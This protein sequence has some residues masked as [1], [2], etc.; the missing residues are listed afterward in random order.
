M[1]SRSDW[2]NPS[3]GILKN[4]CLSV[5]QPNYGTLMTEA[6]TE[7]IFEPNYLLEKRSFIPV[8][9]LKLKAILK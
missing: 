6:A 9:S 4:Y 2:N 1:M 8:K 7:V 5:F 3:T